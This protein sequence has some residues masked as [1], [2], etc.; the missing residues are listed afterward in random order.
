M[1]RTVQQ[2]RSRYLFSSQAGAA[3]PEP[4][5]IAAGDDQTALPFHNECIAAGAALPAGA[6]ARKKRYPM[7]PR[8]QGDSKTTWR[9]L[10]RPSTGVRRRTYTCVIN[11]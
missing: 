8:C 1:A 3:R 5:P 7:L 6:T 11:L 9:A 2:K 10:P 4:E